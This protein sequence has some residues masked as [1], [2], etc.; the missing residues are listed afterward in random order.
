MARIG[1]EPAIRLWNDAAYVEDRSVLVEG[2]AGA[3]KCLLERD[4]P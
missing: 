4:G 1:S 3:W 2:R